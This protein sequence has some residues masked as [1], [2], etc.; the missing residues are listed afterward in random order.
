MILSLM[1][2]YLQDLQAVTTSQR[3]EIQLLEEKLKASEWD[4]KQLRKANAD[5]RDSI[6]EKDLTITELKETK[7]NDNDTIAHVRRLL[8]QACD[9]IKE[10]VNTKTDLRGQIDDLKNDKK[11]LETRVAAVEQSNDLKSQRIST[12][13]KE[14]TE[15]DKKIEALQATTAATTPPSTKPAPSTPSRNPPPTE[16]LINA[17]AN[18]AVDDAQNQDKLRREAAIRAAEDAKN[19]INRD[20][21]EPVLAT[22]FKQVTIGPNGERIVRKAVKDGADTTGTAVSGADA[23]VSGSVPSSGPAPGTPPSSS[24]TPKTPTPARERCSEFFKKGHCR[25]GDSCSFKHDNSGKREV[26]SPTNRLCRFFQAGYCQ[27]GDR[28]NYAHI[29]TDETVGGTGTN[30]SGKRGQKNKQRK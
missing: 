21:V 4:N 26:D 20:P 22:N 15:K 1:I 11:A 7:V 8:E 9:R 23:E 6:K 3:A 18:F 27:Y 29:I 28:C 25:F 12:L 19:G 5:L 30:R 16:S 17:W 2:L 14:A 10:M 24:T 13:G